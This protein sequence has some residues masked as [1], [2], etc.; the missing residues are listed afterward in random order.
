MHRKLNEDCA[1]N[2]RETAAAIREIQTRIES[3]TLKLF[4]VISENE[5]D[6][7]ETAAILETLHA[8]R[9]AEDSLSGLAYRCEPQ[10]EW[11][12]GNGSILRAPHIVNR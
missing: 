12:G 10:P 7:I 8:L 11:T 1:N 4:R 6:A 5:V 9:V 3:L 2:W